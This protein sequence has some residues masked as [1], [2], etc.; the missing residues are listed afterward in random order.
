MTLVIIQFNSKMRGP[1]NVKKAMGCVEWNY[2]LKC[3][4][5]RAFVPEG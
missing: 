1:Y 5:F 2:L 3:S 4:E